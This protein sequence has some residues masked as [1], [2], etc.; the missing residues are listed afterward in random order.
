[1][2]EED[3]RI[4]ARAS[5]RSSSVDAPREPLLDLVRREIL[6]SRQ[7]CV[8]KASLAKRLS[9]QEELV[10]ACLG[11]LESE[12]LLERREVPKTE[13]FSYFELFGIH[14]IHSDIRWTGSFW[15]L[16]PNDWELIGA[17]RQEGRSHPSKAERRKWER[18]N[19][20]KDT[21]WDGMAH[22]VVRG[23]AFRRA[24]V[25]AGL[26]DDPYLEWQCACGAR[27]PYLEKRCSRC[28]ESRLKLNTRGVETARMSSRA[29]GDHPPCKRCGL[30]VDL[31]RKKG[32]RLHVV[33]GSK[34]CDHGLVQKIMEE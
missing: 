2:D 22:Y 12:G 13:T 31:M 6:V 29:Q 30:P 11:R 4:K 3:F 18:K 17:V 1:M 15:G 20:P 34:K 9:A 26:P 7:D 25:A 10:G 8:L 21:G 5:G 28:T 32:S 23:E 27:N 14:S 16:C 19:P 24:A 33:H